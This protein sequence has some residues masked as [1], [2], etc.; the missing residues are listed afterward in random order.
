MSRPLRIAMFVGTF[1]VPSETFILR[2]IAGLIDLGH[3]VELFAET[4][5]DATLPVQP[6]VIQ[7]GL[8]ERTTYLDLPPE[9]S[10]WELPAQP[11]DGETWIPGAASGIPNRRRLEEARQIQSR[12]RMCCPDLVDEVSSERHYGYRAASLSALHRLDRLCRTGKRYDIVH[13]HFGPVGESY[14]FVRRLWNTPLVVSFHGYDFCTIPRKEGRNCYQRLFAETDLVTANSD[15]TAGEL[16]KLGCPDAKLR[17]LPMGLDPD[18]FAFRERTLDRPVRLITVAR[19]VPI[20]GHEFC[21]RALAE[22]RESHPG[23]HYDI[24]GDGPLRAPLEQLSKELGL[25]EV[26]TFHGA[27]PGP[28]AQVLLNSAHV[29]LLCSVSVEGDQEGQGLSLLEAQACGLPVIATRHGALPEGVQD[30]ESGWLVPERDAAALAKQIRAA[31]EQSSR[32]PSMGRAGRNFVA[33]RFDLR[34]LNRQ[35]A[36]LYEEAILG[37]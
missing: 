25:G 16:R 1:P 23:I 9:C 8:L 21:L 37:E 29:S 10:P 7:H 18:A 30:G 27:L 2:Q 3:T 34:T 33:G 20:K 5:G 11:E 14:R 32:W 31:I 19:L 17:K 22:L 36:E 26:A 6:E 35:L 24:V 12:C 15:H 28:D 13:A 4:R